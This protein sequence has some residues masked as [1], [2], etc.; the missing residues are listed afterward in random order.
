LKNKRIAYIIK[1]IDKENLKLN[2]L[3]SVLKTSHKIM[4]KYS[5]TSDDEVRHCIGLVSGAMLY[6]LNVKELI[7]NNTII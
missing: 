7:L 6:I 1:T 3:D 2:E 5:N 4:K